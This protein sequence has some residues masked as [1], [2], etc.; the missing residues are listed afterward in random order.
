MGLH[1]AVHAARGAGL[2]AAG[3]AERDGSARLV[4][5]E[6]AEG[7]ILGGRGSAAAAGV[8]GAAARQCDG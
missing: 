6:E 4:G 5:E 7:R 8:C 1:N 2:H 3:A